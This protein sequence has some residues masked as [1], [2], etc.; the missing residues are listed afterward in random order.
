MLGLDLDLKDNIFGLDPLT[1]E[2]EIL[3]LY[4]IYVLALLASLNS[5]SQFSTKRR[6]AS[7]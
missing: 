1:L 7:K 4:F 2:P 3:A 6:M 5:I